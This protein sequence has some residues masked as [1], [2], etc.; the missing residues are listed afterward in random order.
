MDAYPG[1]MSS[2][3][4]NHGLINLHVKLVI[5]EVRSAAS[6]LLQPPPGIWGLLHLMVITEVVMEEMSHPQLQYFGKLIM[7]TSGVRVQPLCSVLH[8]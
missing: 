7:A 4:F 8:Q 2:G 6:C 1:S 3:F 5:A